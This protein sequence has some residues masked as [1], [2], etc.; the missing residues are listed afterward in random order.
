MNEPFRRIPLPNGLELELFDQSNRY[1]GDYHRVRI[2]LRCRV[3]IRPEWLRDLPSDVAPKQACSLLGEALVYER[4]LERMGVATAE[5]ERIKEQLIDGFL[6]VGG[7]YL[8]AP[9]FPRRFFLQHLRAPRLG[10]KR[11]GP[12]SP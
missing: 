12:K 9:D 7:S 2:L 10:P 4:H 1:F 11:F 6:T 8:G 3:E 5:L